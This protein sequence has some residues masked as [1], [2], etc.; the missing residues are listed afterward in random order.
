MLV[1][2][3]GPNCKCTVDAPEGHE[4]YFCSFECACYAGHF[5]VTKGWLNPPKVWSEELGEWVD[6]KD[7]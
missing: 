1:N 7:I 5:S 2:C 4:F 6:K 3:C